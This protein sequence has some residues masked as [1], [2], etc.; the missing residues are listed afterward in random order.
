MPYSARNYRRRRFT[1]FVVARVGE[2]A[3][4]TF[5]RVLLAAGGNVDPAAHVLRP[6]FGP[7]SVRV[8]RDWR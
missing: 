2:G 3:H 5:L 8:V 7:P 4:G 6:A 1:G